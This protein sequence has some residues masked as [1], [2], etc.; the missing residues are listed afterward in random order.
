[1]R[2]SGLRRLGYVKPSPQSAEVVAYDLL[3]GQLPVRWAHSLG[4]RTRSAVC[5]RLLDADGAEVLERAAILHDLG[6]SPYIALT[7]FNA[8][9]GARIFDP[10]TTT[11]G[12]RTSLL[13]TPA[14][15]WRQNC[16]TCPMPWLIST[17]R[18]G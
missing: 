15:P 8:L 6:Y 18:M 2:L 7:G 16:E 17:R 9:D 1:M 4:V 14:L 12:L 11:N 13:I 3:A 5:R 10:L